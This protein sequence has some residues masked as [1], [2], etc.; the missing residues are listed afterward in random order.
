L[1]V[2]DAK[3]KPSLLVR[4]STMNLKKDGKLF[5]VPLYLIGQLNSLFEFA[6]DLP[7]LT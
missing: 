3:Y 1:L 2:Y 6:R 5:N 7:T 4:S